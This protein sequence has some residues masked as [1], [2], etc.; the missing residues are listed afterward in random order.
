ME[1]EEEVGEKKTRKRQER[2]GEKEKTVLHNL[3]GSFLGNV[4]PEP[5]QE[6]GWAGG[7][8]NCLSKWVSSPPPSSTG[9]H[10]PLVRLARTGMACN[11]L[12]S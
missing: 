12:H 5:S 3:H 1:E 6:G 7:G 2:K 9:A 10:L 8:W 4:S 11:C